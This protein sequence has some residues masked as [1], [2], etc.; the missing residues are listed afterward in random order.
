MYTYTCMM[1]CLVQTHAWYPALAVCIHSHMV[2]HPNSK[3]QYMRAY[4]YKQYPYG[5]N[6][7]Y[8]HL[9]IAIPEGLWLAIGELNG[10]GTGV[11][12]IA[13]SC[14]IRKVLGLM[15]D[16]YPRPAIPPTAAAVIPHLFVLNWSK[17]LLS[18]QQLDLLL[19]LE[20]RHYQ[21]Q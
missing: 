11:A 15:L 19:F 10:T 7:I 8:I 16:S 13:M 18:V 9:N 5:P 1:C 14:G 3:S 4:R 17:W 6:M 2:L 20:L 21:Y 12:G